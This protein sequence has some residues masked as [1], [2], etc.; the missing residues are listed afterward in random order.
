M[1]THSLVVKQTQEDYNNT[2][3]PRCPQR[4]GEHREWRGFYIYND[5]V[6]SSVH[7]GLGPQANWTLEF[8]LNIWNGGQGGAGGCGGGD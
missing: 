2:Y 8:T 6:G 7:P 1:G 4:A 5:P 3:L